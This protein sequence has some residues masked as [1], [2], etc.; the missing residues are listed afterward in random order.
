MKR[1]VCVLLCVCLSL[2]LALP[3]LASG[4]DV[5][6]EQSLA[7]SLK[8]LGLFQG[9]SDTDLGLELT[10]T[11]TQALVM[12]IRL[13]GEEEAAFESGRTHGFS[14]VPRWA[15]GYVSYG[16]EHK[17][18]DGVG[19]RA[20]G[21]DAPASAAMFL[22]FVLRA[23]G[24]TEGED[25][26]FLWSDPFALARTVG[27]L[28]D[29]VD[30]ENFLRAD[31]VLI[32]YAALGATVGGTG[33]TL[34]D[35]LVKKGAVSADV[36]KVYDP[37]A[38]KNGALSEAVYENIHET[39]IFSELQSGVEYDGAQYYKN[40]GSIIQ[41][42]DAGYEKYGYY[43]SGAAKMAKQINSAAE[44]LRG[45][46][47]VFALYAPNSL[48]TML[49]ASAY[50]TIFPSKATEGE[51]IASAYA[52]LGSLVTP[53]DAYT[54]LRAHNDEYIA[55]RTDHHWTALGAYYAYEQWAKSAGFE[56]VPLS[57]YGAVELNRHFG[58]F[59]SMTKSPLMAQN[60][61]T[62]T[63]YYPSWRSSVMYYDSSSRGYSGDLI[64]DRSSSSDKYSSF[65]G[66]DHPFAVITNEDAP[67]DNA[68]L[69][70][71]DS[72]G[73]PFTVF[74]AAHYKT[75]C[76]VDPRY[77]GSL[78]ETLTLTGLQEKYGIDDVIF[79][80]SAVLMQSDGFAGYI[81]KIVK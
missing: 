71:K 59:Y 75:T 53:V 69:I 35:T 81:E 49:S 50:S 24:Y 28:P 44:L 68:C 5:S 70:F 47:R 79:I 6:F 33:K 17:L 42:D 66:G 41:I 16:V 2:S 57:D 78:S 55:L 77:Y 62:V 26:D 46:S 15:D 4:R 27:I 1:L 63:V 40:W 25:G 20:F 10:P 51:G 23:L 36:S 54:T 22:T 31:V 7:A 67:N 32:S 65:L 61:D 12:L 8:E 29:G 11:R 39:L 76:V 73:N 80:G 45:K 18:T 14:D 52:K 30:T 56:P 9:I 3:A 74:V 21:S 58:L 19:G 34:L 38:V 43:D 48:G 60:P 64:A 72:Y 37:N 13:L